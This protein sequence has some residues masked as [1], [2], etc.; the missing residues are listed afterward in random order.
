MPRKAQSN[1]V[2]MAVLAAL[3]VG[4]I[5]S[6]CFFLLHAYRITP[7][8]KAKKNP[9]SS[10]DGTWISSSRGQV[11]NLRVDGTGRFRFSKEDNECSYFEWTHESGQFS[12][13]QYPKKRSLVWYI[14]RAMLDDTPTS[15]YD[16]VSIA[17]EEISLTSETGE[18]VTLSRFCDANLESAP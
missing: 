15:R 6:L 2:Q 14:R 1:S 11:L 12:I 4:F 17:D 18:L 8:A 9:S 10:F 5:S 3:L 16:I 13:Y 7:Q